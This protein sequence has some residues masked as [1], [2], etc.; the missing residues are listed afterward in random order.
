MIVIIVQNNINPLMQQRVQYFLLF[1]LSPTQT[2]WMVREHA[3]YNCPCEKHDVLKSKPQ[4]DRGVFRLTSREGDSNFF[5]YSGSKFT[6]KIFGNI[7]VEF[8]IFLVFFFFLM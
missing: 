6:S 7:S 2:N 1:Y 3:K 8:L 4:T 5:F